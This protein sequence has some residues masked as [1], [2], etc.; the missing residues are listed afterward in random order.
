M[1]GARR[2]GRRGR[3][4]ALNILLRREVL[5]ALL[6][7]RLLRWIALARWR[8]LRWVS[9]WRWA[10]LAIRRLLR[11]LRRVHRLLR[12]S[13]ADGILLLILWLRHARLKKSFVV[14]SR[15]NELLVQLREVVCESL[16]RLLSG[17]RLHSPFF[18]EYL[19]INSINFGRMLNVL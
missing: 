7:E 2:F 12:W 3:V 16:V 11:V 9:V 4:V 17:V 8:P 6:C 1:G 19:P 13:C 10:L 18:C 14:S 15:F 5:L